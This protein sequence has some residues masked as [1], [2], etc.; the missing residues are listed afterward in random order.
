M[1]DEQL[2]GVSHGGCTGID[3]G[4]H[5][6]SDQIRRVTVF[7]FWK[8]RKPSM[9]TLWVPQDVHVGEVLMPWHGLQASIYKLSGNLAGARVRRALNQCNNMGC[10][11]RHTGSPIPG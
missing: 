4:V 5:Q 9:I 1:Q 2:F 11:I 3:V 10:E 8:S 6:D 7:V